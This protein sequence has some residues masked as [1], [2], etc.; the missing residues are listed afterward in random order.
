VFSLN[1]SKLPHRNV[2]RWLGGYAREALYNLLDPPPA[3]TR[4]LL[5]ALCDH[6]EPLWGDADVERGRTRVQRW[7]EQYPR[8]ASE[9]RDADGRP[10]QH[11]FFFP[12]EQYR[13]EFLDGLASL[14]RQGLGEVELHLHHDGD[15]A[16]SLKRD[17]LRSA[18]LFAEHGHL[19]RDREGKLR[20]G[21][22]HGNWCLANSRRDGRW[23]GVDSEL[24][25]LFDTG[26]YAD[27]TFPSA[28]D[29]TQPGI[30]NQIY[31]PLGDL[32][33]A[34]AHERGSRAR[35][36]YNLTDRILMIQGPLAL[37]RREGRRGLRIDSAAL[38][39]RDPG[40][41]SRLRTWVSQGIHVAGRPEWVFVKL[42]THGAPDEQGE[43]LLGEPGRQMHRELARS[44]NDGHDYVLHYVTARE[45]YNIACAAM[46]GRAGN[47]NEY[48]NY[49]L[50]APPVA[51]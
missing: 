16:D 3:G 24:S 10:P 19:T 27:F 18:Q 9:F 32:Q 1:L 38:T 25:V 20:Y 21:F 2:H 44:Y 40:S 43:A 37:A 14:A 5:V 46:N 13:P 8:L 17:L 50:P 31:W 29:E 7:V 42:H 45:M 35:V 6:Y 26:C 12:G 51:S 30:V 36:G 11:S 4:H 49:V 34:R 23:C 22:I 15:D 28:P 41:K 47:P 39:A 48:R 33:Q